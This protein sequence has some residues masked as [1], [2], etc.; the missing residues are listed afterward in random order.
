MEPLS[1]R[2]GNRLK[3]VFEYNRNGTYNIFTFIAS[4]GYRRHVT[5]QEHR[6]EFDWAEGIKYLVVIYPIAKKIT[7]MTGNLNMHKIASV[8]KRYPDSEARRLLKQFDTDYTPKYGSWLDMAEIDLNV[9]TANVY[10]D[11]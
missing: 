6:T 3:I 8:Y 1:L 5:V 4:L 7:L 11:V 2:T 10:Q 9:M